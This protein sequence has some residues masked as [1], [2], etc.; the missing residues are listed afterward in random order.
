MGGQLQAGDMVDVVPIG[1]HQSP[2]PFE[3]V[4]VL[5]VVNDA[6][7][8][9][10]SGIPVGI[11]LAIPSRSRTEFAAASANGGILVTRKIVVAN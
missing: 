7:A 6:K 2:K 10:G 5:N 11:T 9:K 4:L 3:N 8:E 1:S